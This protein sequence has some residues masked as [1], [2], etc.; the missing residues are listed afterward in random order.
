MTGR[1]QMRENSA[2]GT[3]CALGFRDLSHEK[4][5]KPDRHTNHEK[6]AGDAEQAVVG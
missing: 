4:A 5:V 2:R 1:A 3:L 6:D